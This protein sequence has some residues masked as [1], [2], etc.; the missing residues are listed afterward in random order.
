[1]IKTLKELGTEK[2]YLNIK[3]RPYMTSLIVNTVV[4]VNGEKLK[5]LPL[6]SGKRQE[7]SL[8]PLL[9]NTPWSLKR[10]GNDLA[11]NQ[12]LKVPGRAIR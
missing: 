1:M 10:D 6:R 11:T 5:E 8:S 9:F 4:N 3:Q 2:M 7:C 12:Q